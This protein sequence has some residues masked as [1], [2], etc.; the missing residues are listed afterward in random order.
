[1]KMELGDAQRLFGEIDAGYLRAAPCHGLG[2]DAAAAADI[3]HARTLQ[4]R[5][6]RDPFQAQ[7]IDFM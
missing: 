3:E 1:M 4:A 6:A 2:Q 7:R 5:V